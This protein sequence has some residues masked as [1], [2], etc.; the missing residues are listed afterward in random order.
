M[1]MIRR[2]FYFITVNGK[3]LGR[4]APDNP[5]LK[6]ILKD[7]N[8]NGQITF[9]SIISD[10]RIEDEKSAAKLISAVSTAIYA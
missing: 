8:L 4:C 10:K 5:A 9:D 7:N 3:F 2:A 1:G 6:F